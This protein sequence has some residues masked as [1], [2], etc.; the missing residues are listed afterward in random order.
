MSV[1]SSM[2]VLRTLQLAS[3]IIWFVPLSKV[4]GRDGRV[5]D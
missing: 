5:F 2:H 3:V 4:Y 1:A